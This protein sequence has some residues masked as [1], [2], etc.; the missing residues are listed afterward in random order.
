MK[1]GIDQSFTSTGICFID[2]NQLVFYKIISSDKEDESYDRAIQIADEIVFTI[3][4]MNKDI[5]I[6]NIEGLSYGSKG[7][8]TR[9]LAGLQFLIID[10]IKKQNWNYNVIAPQTLK[11]F[12]LKGN[13]SKEELFECLPDNVYEEFDK[14]NKSEK[15][16]LMDAYFLAI[17][18]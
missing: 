18:E 16:D 4:D 11:K 10:R 1:V 12:V 5:N 9:N 14:Y 3:K 2:N 17:Y 6:I 15:F 7:D 13:S 8:A